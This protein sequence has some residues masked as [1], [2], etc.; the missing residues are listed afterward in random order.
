[1]KVE[2]IKAILKSKRA[3]I[4]G[5]TVGGALV[6]TLLGAIIISNG[7]IE[8]NAI[9]IDNKNVI[10]ENKEQAK[11]NNTENVDKNINDEGVDNSTE[12][13]N[14]TELKEEDNLNNEDNSK[15]SKNIAN[16]VNVKQESK[17]NAVSNNQQNTGNTQSS[18]NTQN[19]T[20]N[21]VKPAE[22][23]TNSKPSTGS[24]SNNKPNNSTSNTPKPDQHTH[25]WIPVTQVVHHDEQGHNEKILISEAWTEEIPV[26]EEQAR[27]IC[28]TCNA[29]LTGLDISAHVKK[30]MLAGEDKGGHRTEWK[31]VQ[32]GSNKINHDAV[33]EN[34]W[35]VDKAAWDET[36]TTGHK[37]SSCGQTK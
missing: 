19:N 24:S 32:V 28:N 16:E 21:N 13:N 15:D 3:K 2:K 7:Y 18:S 35:V 30:H 36:V 4:I 37:C 11:D 22:G 10:N 25:N 17:N 31:K 29:D 1:M 27:D 14:N 33:Y 6:L 9:A 23:N 34:K 12:E 20:A 8:G 26:Y 5:G